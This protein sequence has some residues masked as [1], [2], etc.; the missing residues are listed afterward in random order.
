[1]SQKY[2]KKEDLPTF[3]GSVSCVLLTYLR[4]LEDFTLGI[5]WESA[6]DGSKTTSDVMKAP[7]FA[8]FWLEFYDCTWEIQ[9]MKYMGYMIGYMCICIYIYVKRWDIEIYIH[10]LYI[11]IWNMVVDY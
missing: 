7:P 9:Y 6:D 10:M 8:F 3:N 5:G 2:P 11:Y 4:N 1:M